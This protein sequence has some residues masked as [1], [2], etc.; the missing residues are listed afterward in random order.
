MKNRPQRARMTLALGEHFSPSVEVSTSQHHE[1]ISA[2]YSLWNFYEANREIFLS[3]DDKAKI[4]TFK[5]WGTHFA[6][7]VLNWV[8]GSDT[9]DEFP[10]TLS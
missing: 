7:P 10:H 2:N 6:P 8:D 3:D 5:K 4:K 9:I 1:Y